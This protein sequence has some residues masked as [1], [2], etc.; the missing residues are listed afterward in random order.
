MPAMAKRTGNGQ[1]VH[2][3]HRPVVDRFVLG[4]R[5]ENE[6]NVLDSPLST[7]S[8]TPRFLAKRPVWRSQRSDAKL[9]SRN[10]VVT[11][12]PVMKRGLRP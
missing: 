1:L 12:Q 11:T 10:T 6:W 7:F 8:A 9:K 2:G 4:R 5:D 3:G